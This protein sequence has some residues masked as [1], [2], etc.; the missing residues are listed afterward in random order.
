[1]TRNDLARIEIEA[2]RLRAETI[3]DMIRAIFHRT[4]RAGVAG[5][6]TA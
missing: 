6:R 1:M 2:R 3:A 4:P 5:V